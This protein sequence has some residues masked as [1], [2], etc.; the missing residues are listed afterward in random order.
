MKYFRL[1]KIDTLFGDQHS[2]P[3]LFKTCLGR[4]DRSFGAKKAHG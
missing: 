3:Q 2:D 1:N 4:A